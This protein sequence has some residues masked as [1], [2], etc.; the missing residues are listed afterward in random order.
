M[1]TQLGIVFTG[2]EGP[3]PQAIARLL[4]GLETKAL[5][6]A[7][8]CGLRLAEEAG[9][10]PDWIVGDMDS[11]GGDGPGSLA[12]YPGERVV[13]HAAA[14]DHSDTELALS[15]LWEKGCINAGRRE[16]PGSKKPW[17]TIAPN[18]TTDSVPAFKQ[19]ITPIPL[20]L[21]PPRL[22]ASA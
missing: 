5:I 11:L 1:E 17:C 8:D 20:P 21:L 22:C 16:V 14:K 9:L 2:G 3:E 12:Q 10:S 4:A 13:R 18:D 15:L 7:A 19:R 6:V